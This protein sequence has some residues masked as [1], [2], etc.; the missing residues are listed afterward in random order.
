[1]VPNPI[2]LVQSFGHVQLLWPHGLQHTKPPLSIANSQNLLKLMSTESVMPSNCLILVVPFFS[3]LQSFL[4]S[5]SY[6]S[7][8]SVA[9]NTINIISVFKKFKSIEIILSICSEHN[10]MKL[11]INHKK[12]NRGGEAI[13]WRLLFH[14]D[15]ATKK[16]IG[17]LRKSIRRLKNSLR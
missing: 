16:L 14:F 6:F 9:K 5:G 10:G 13:T 4:A 17:Q 3:R 12:R 7:N 1:M 8:E 11:K 2:S 15:N